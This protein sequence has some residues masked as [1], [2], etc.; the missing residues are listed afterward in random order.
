[1]PIIRIPSLKVGGL[2]YP[3]QNSFQPNDHGTTDDLGI[4]TLTLPHSRQ[5][6]SLEKFIL[7]A[8]GNAEVHPVACR[9]LLGPTF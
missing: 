1:M 6:V 4:F 8:L 2:V 3:Q 5:V 9:S 7:R